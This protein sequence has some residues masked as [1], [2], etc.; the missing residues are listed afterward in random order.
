MKRTTILV[1]VA[2]TLSMASVALGPAAQAVDTTILDTL[3]AATPTT[4]FSVFG[5]GGMVIASSQLV[6]PRFM[7]NEDTVITEI[8]AFLNNCA[9]I[10]GGVP[11]CPDALPLTV[12]IRPSV[13]GLPDPS[14]VLATLVLSHDDDPLLVS[15]ESVSPNLKLEPGEYFALFAPQQEQDVGFVLAS[16]NE[17]RAGIVTM[18]FLDPTSGDASA[19]DQFAA[20]RIAGHSLGAGDLLNELLNDVIDQNAGP[21]ASLESILSETGSALEAGNTTSACQLLDAF[22]RATTAQSG[23]S[24]LPDQ[25]AALIDAAADIQEALDC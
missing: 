18:G 17:Y 9:S 8:G 16:T 22:V 6:G 14:T 21:G 19:S 23:K 4:T 5:S 15:Y 13:A 1:L 2:V 20:V 10:V 25:A 7:V 12:Q 11:Q 3:G 24:L